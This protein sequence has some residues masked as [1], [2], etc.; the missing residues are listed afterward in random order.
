M[1]NTQYSTISKNLKIIQIN[2]NSLIS[3]SRRYN[4]QQFIN[5][6]NP[7]ILLLNETKLN[8]RHR[9]LF[10]NYIMIRKDRKDSKQGGG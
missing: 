8:S 9:L 2:V 4:L 3:I 5:K 6:H 7:D 1:D 10:Y